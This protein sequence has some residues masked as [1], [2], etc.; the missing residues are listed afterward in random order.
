MK[1][2]IAR[3][4]FKEQFGQS[5]HFLITSLI[6]LNIIEKSE[7][8]IKPEEFSTSWNPKDKNNS[9]RRSR[10]FLLGSFL[11]YAVDGVDMY[12][13]LLNKKPK[14]IEDPEFS[15]LFDSAGQSVY[16]KVVGIESYFKIDKTL[17]CL[18]FLMITWRNNIVHAMADNKLEPSQ[19]KHL[20]RHQ[21][22]IR[23]S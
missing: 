15:L 5:N 23:N 3:K 9:A 4:E 12:L 19:E 18:V 20:L 8:I 7:E 22:D 16:K 13:S 10:S 6:G 21:Q 14:V 11:S 17:T 1:R 2:T